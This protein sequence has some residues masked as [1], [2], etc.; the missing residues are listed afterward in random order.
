SPR[1][2]P[3]RRSRSRRAPTPV[4]PRA[5]ASP[6]PSPF[7][8]RTDARASS[9]T[10]AVRARR[11]GPLLRRDDRSGTEQIATQVRLEDG[12]LAT[13]PFEEHRRV[14]LLLVA[15]VLEDRAQLAVLGRVDAL[16][17]PVDRLQLLDDAHDRAVH[18][19][20]L[21]TQQ[22]ER[23]VEHLGVFRHGA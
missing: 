21:L 23:L 3:P 2:R 13:D 17:V 10:A 18:V 15:V 14:L 7:A 9:R 5:S 1:A 19:A 16:A 11:L 12:I 4:R 6:S 20:C 22:L 8:E